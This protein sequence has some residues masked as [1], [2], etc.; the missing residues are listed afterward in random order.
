MIIGL[1]LPSRHMWSLRKFKRTTGSV[2]DVT[3]G[4]TSRPLRRVHRGS[5]GKWA[6]MGSL[7]QFSASGCPPPLRQAHAPA[8]R[9]GPSHAQ[10]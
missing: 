10:S 2:S 4:V 6:A 9:M 1:F 8:A 5:W 3:S 7:G